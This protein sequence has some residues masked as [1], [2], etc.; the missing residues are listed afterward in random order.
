MAACIR[1]R[2]AELEEA[3]P[4]SATRSRTPRRS[5]SAPPPPPPG[6]AAR[7]AAAGG[8]ED[9]LPMEQQ[10]PILDEHIRNAAWLE[11]VRREPCETGLTPAIVHKWVPETKAEHNYVN[12][13][14]ERLVGDATVPAS[15]AEAPLVADG[16]VL[17]A[18]ARSQA[19][20]GAAA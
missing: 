8:R 4:G 14:A 7:A 18:P 1:A 9:G 5:T 11:M 17:T 10:D 15:G 2:L 12:A 16:T 6:T 3:S 19:A 20:V 13:W